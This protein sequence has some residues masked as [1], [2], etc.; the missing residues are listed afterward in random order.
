MFIC[1]NN[2]R[3]SH[4]GTLPAIRRNLQSHM[5]HDLPCFSAR[6]C[7]VKVLK[8]RMLCV[9]VGKGGVMKVGVTGVRDGRVG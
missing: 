5:R 7:C 6:S 2:A 9:G 1:V 3:I 4:S 8:G